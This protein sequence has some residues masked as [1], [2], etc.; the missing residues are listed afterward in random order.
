M[1]FP[2]AAGCMMTT[3]CPLRLWIQRTFWLTRGS[4]PLSGQ[5]KHT[6]SSHSELLDVVTFAVNKLG[7]DWE[8]DVDQAQSSSKLDDHFFT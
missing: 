3:F 8:V 7:L 2:L 4:L 5:E 6:S 1:L